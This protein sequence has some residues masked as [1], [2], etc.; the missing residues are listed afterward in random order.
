M[1]NYDHEELS[2]MS[3]ENDCKAAPKFV[4]PILKLDGEKGYFYRL[5]E[6]GQTES[7]GVEIKAV[8]LKNR[9][10]IRGYTKTE[11][12][13][14]REYNGWQ[15]QVEL[16]ESRK[17]EKGTQ[18]QMVGHGT[19]QEL[20]KQFADRIS[21]QMVLYVLL[22]ESSE[23]VKVIV[24]G[25]GV[26]YLMDYFNQFEGGEHAH[27]FVT[28]MTVKEEFNESLRKT[29][30]A[31]GFEKG[32][33]IPD[34]EAMDVIAEEIKRVNSELQKVEAYYAKKALEYDTDSPVELSEVNQDDIPVVEEGVNSELDRAS[35]SES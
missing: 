3:G 9:R 24:R 16:I 1:S 32:D 26:S 20:K 10:T 19:Y 17:T 31:M 4:V 35:E 28:V 13:Y 34:D 22:Q 12:Y 23:V 29:Y 18:T 15:T 30:Y 21:M 27:Q 14:S 33:K 8:I 5:I 2:Q 25:K 11:R 6:D 7:I